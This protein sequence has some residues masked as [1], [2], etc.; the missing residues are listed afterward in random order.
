MSPRVRVFTPSQMEQYHD[1]KIL[2]RPINKGYVDELA[3][4]L[5]DGVDLPPIQV[6]V[7]TEE[8]GKKSYFMTD[9]NQTYR[10]CQLAKKSHSV[11]ITAYDTLADALADQLKRNLTH[12][13]RITAG[14]RDAR[15][16]ELITKHNWSTSQVADSVGMSKASVSRIYRGV[17]NVT[18]TGQ[19][20]AVA[21]QPRAQ[22]VPH[23]L[24]GTQFIRAVENLHLTL[25]KP[26]ARGEV[27]A[28]IY[29][30][31]RRPEDVQAFVK[32]LREVAD[33]LASLVRQPSAT[34]RPVRAARREQRQMELPAA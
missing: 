1:P 8:D 25:D 34:M 5:K 31:A 21:G 33:A 14:Q 18:G 26:E 20:G 19:R 2:L 15:I 6:A 30:P 32:K 27:L 23:A 22:V 10:A 9:G 13:L 28:A 17:Q 7:Y 3:E 12:G 16:K 11:E 29:N 24:P 4:K